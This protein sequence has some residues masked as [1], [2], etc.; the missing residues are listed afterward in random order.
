VNLHAGVERSVAATKTY[1]AELMALALLSAELDGRRELLEQI[2]RVPDAVAET[3]ELCEPVRNRA[4]RYR[5]MRDCAVIG[6]GL[7]YGTAFEIALKL[8]ELTYVAATPYSSA[9]FRHGPIA[10]VEPGFPVVLIAPHG[11]V[12]EDLAALAESLSVRDAELV[13]ISDRD[14]LA[15]RADLVYTLPPTVEEWLSPMTAVVPG[16]LLSYDL[17]CAKG[18]DPDN[19]RGLRKVTET[20]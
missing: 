7:N 10:V 19:P 12:Y 18:V 8:K 1:T 5:Y 17:A 20:R 15:D 14:E 4:E 16:Q 13:L 6:R 3:L 9:D 11:S 2:R